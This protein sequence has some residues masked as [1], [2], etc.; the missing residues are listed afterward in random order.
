MLIYII[1][2]SAVNS[3]V[4]TVDVPGIHSF[5]TTV[6]GTAVLGTAALGTAA[7][8]TAA[9]GTAA[10]GV[11]G[12]ELLGRTGFGSSGMDVPCN[13]RLPGICKSTSH[14]DLKARNMRA[15]VTPMSV[16]TVPGKS[17]TLLTTFRIP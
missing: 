7:L 5:G 17:V 1:Q 8:G 3:I 4:D 16:V 13:M 15:M 12:T 6:L 2:H 10:L 14:S 9:L 11:F